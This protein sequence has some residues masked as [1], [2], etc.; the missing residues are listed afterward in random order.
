MQVTID[1]YLNEQ[2]RHVSELFASVPAREALRV[3]VDLIVDAASS[4]A[5]APGCYSVIAA[6]ELGSPT[7]EPEPVS[8]GTQAR[9]ARRLFRASLTSLKQVAAAQWLQTRAPSCCSA[10][11]TA[12][13]WQPESAFRPTRPETSST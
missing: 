7:I 11:S 2:S 9:F 3:Y 12:F 6:V 5:P 4:D 1:T 10:S 8:N 13:R